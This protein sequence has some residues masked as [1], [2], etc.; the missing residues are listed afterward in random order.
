MFSISLRNYIS[1]TALAVLSVDLLATSGDI[2]MTWSSPMFPKLYSNDTTV[3]PLGTPITADED[4]WIGSL[5]NIGAIVGPLPFGFISE[6]YGRKIAL[7]AIAVPHIISY[8]TMAFANNVYIFYFGR[9]LGGV[10]V[11]GGYTLLPMYIA[12]VAEESERGIYSVT[13]GIFWAFGNFFPYAVGPFLSVMWF[14]LALACFPLAFLLAFSIFGR[15]TPYYL[16]SAGKTLEAKEVLM[17]LRSKSEKDVEVELELI[18]TTLDKEEHGRLSDVLK[19]KGLRKALFISV[20]LL[21]FQQLSGVNAISFYMQPIFE[22]SG[23]SISSDWSAL[24]AGI[25]IFIFSLLIPVV[26]DRFDRTVL[27]TFASLL[28]SLCLSAIGIFFYIKDKT[29][30]SSKSIFWLP[31]ASLVVNTFAFQVGFAAIPWTI[32]SELF[33]N[34]V[35]N[36]AASATSISCYLTSFLMTKFFDDMT[37]SLGVYGTFWFFAFSCILCA[38]FTH[39]YVPETRGKTFMEIQQIL[40]K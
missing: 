6:R 25:C 33:P 38:A 3:N 17:Y 19:N 37:K 9:L 21:A 35:K 27:I 14:N 23:T 12:E 29:D 11:G 24:S 28:M 34:D 1:C 16:M 40:Q 39:F 20:A 7:L 13:L 10:A 5:L 15:E 4:S 8:V 36:V 26:V 22:A 32:S 2:T 30:L 18:K 31:L